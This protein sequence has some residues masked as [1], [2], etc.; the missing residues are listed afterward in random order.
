[1]KKLVLYG[2]VGLMLFGA[3]FAGSWMMQPKVEP[4]EKDP[5]ASDMPELDLTADALESEA[6]A[7]DQ[8]NGELPVAV[9]PRPINPEEIVRYG[10]TIRNREEA[11]KQREEALERERMQLQLVVED[12]RTEQRE[13]EAIQ[14]EI[15]SKVNAAEKLI[16]EIANQRQQF[17]DERTDAQ[18]ELDKIK[19]AQIE[20]KSLEAD[21]LKRMSA[22]FQNMDPAK[23]AELLREMSNNGQMTMVVQLLGNFEEREA[24]KILAEM[25]DKNLVTQLAEQYRGLKRPDKTK[26]R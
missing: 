1:M 5:M 11:I 7:A 2:V 8:G 19:K 9:R 18:D 4:E 12:I 15:Q 3:S 22:W 23:A 14:G 6:T 20:Y 16:T 24:A 26:K 21:N 17:T 13:L 10:L 25:E